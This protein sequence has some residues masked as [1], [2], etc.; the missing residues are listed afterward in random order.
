M[1]RAAVDG[2]AAALASLSAFV[3]EFHFAERPDVFKPVDLG[4]LESWFRAAT[5]DPSWQILIAEVAG[6]AAGYVAVMDGS[7]LESAFAR[8]RRWR[9]IEQLSVSANHRRRGVASAL[10]A[11]VA[12][13]AL[14]DGISV[15][16][17]NTWA[18]NDVARQSFQRLGFLERNVRYE[19]QV[20]AT[21]KTPG[22]R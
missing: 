13:S 16:E 8:P 2:D 7:R 1:I 21:G 11:R 12:A 19:R 9:E 4:A 18:F 14:S 22:S 10:L 15:L 6:T 3:Q 17:L 20:R 5:V